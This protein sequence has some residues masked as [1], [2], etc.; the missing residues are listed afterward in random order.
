MDGGV[1]EELVVW[2]S[3][4]VDE[5]DDCWVWSIEMMGLL[6]PG[7]GTGM[8]HFGRGIWLHYT[9]RWKVWLMLI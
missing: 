5:F 4:W 3:E 1:E 2:G 9:R 6:G 7:A 8:L